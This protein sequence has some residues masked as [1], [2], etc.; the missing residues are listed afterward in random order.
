MNIW[1]LLQKIPKF[2]NSQQLFG[3]HL[4]WKQGTGA[5]KALVN[6]NASAET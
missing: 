3:N 4:R 6:T 5:G 2:L 1:A